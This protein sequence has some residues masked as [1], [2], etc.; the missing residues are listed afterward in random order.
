MTAVENTRAQGF[1]ADTATHTTIAPAASTDVELPVR[2]RDGRITADCT[3]QKR[4]RRVIAIPNAAIR[5][6]LSTSGCV[7]VPCTRSRP[8]MNGFVI[9]IVIFCPSTG[10]PVVAS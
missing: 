9:V 10:T 3:S 6:V 7:S 2:A 8:G 4:R 1:R 5:T